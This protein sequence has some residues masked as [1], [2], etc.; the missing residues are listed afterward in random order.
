M[1]YADTLR[2][3]VLN[4]IRCET[5]WVRV[6]S[7]LSCI[8]TCNMSEGQVKYAILSNHYFYTMKGVLICLSRR[9]TPWWGSGISAYHFHENAVLPRKSTRI[10]TISKG[11]AE[12]VPY[13]LTVSSWWLVK[14]AS[15]HCC[16]AVASFLQGIKLRIWAC[17]GGTQK[18]D[19]F[20]NFHA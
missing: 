20:R 7:I 3:H 14:F 9:F 13:H 11:S 10:L 12:R 6:L 18:S 15:I 8:T 1:Q 16:S 17:F 4:L 2:Q 5:M 19:K